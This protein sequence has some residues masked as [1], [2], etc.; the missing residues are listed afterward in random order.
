MR[1]RRL[2]WLADLA[3]DLRFGSRMLVRQP[4]FSAIAVIALAIGIGANTAVFTVAD[5]ILFRPPPFEHPDRLHWIYDTNDEL[6]LTVSSATPP[7]PANFVDW[8]AR[9]HS[10]DYMAAWRNWFYSVAG[11]EGEHHVAE[12]VRGVQVSPAFFAMLGVH[13]AVGRTFEAAEEVPGRDQVVVLTDGFWRR[14]FGADREIVGKTVSIDG[15]PFQVVGVLPAGFY[16]LFSDSA[17]FLPMRVDG[18]F[19]GQRD[20]HSI[21]VVARLAPGSSRADAQS[22]IDL[23]ARDLE[24]AYPEANRGWRAA[25]MPVFPL[26]KNLRPAM[27]LL[28]G[29]V[30]CV[31]LIACINVASLLLVRAGARQR[32]IAVRSAVGASR[33]RLARQMLAE[34]GLIAAAGAFGGVLLAI[35]SLR[36]LAAL[37]PQVQLARPLTMTVD[38]R[39]LLF[40]LAISSVTALALGIVPALRAS[41]TAALRVAAH[42]GD[43]T[44]G[45][46]VLAAAEIALS[47]MLLVAATLLVRSLWNIQQVDRGFR[48]DHLLTMQVWLPPEQYGDASKVSAFH[49]E[50]LRRVGS[51]PGVRAAAIANTRRSSA[52]RSPRP[53]R[54]P[55][56]RDR[57]A[58]MCSSAA[59]S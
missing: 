4:A 26:N 45:G 27:L 59:G 24:R 17:I 5:A 37:V 6:R 3:G 8:R 20:T 23:V 19:R 13:A 11:P 34:S 25:L 46:Q 56:V 36:L 33:G 30:G 7:S 51:L 41:G 52:G 47:L 14:R 2:P 16:F 44:R 29:A 32:E 22:E 28:L 38:A 15:R 42:A 10:F 58:T 48:A 1:R 35:A 12:Q 18:A 57:R 21:I 55:V 40:T 49:R 54:F 43:R 9:L 50:M 39:V 31:L 53:S